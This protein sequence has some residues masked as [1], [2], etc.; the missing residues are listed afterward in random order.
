[1]FLCV[2]LNPAV[3]KRLHVERLRVGRFLIAETLFEQV[4][5]GHSWWTF[6]WFRLSAVPV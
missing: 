4:G 5:D 6:H 3:D 1:M 2:S